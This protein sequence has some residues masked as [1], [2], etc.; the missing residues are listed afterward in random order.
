M[1]DDRS[2]ERAARSWIED[3]PTRAPDSAVERALLTIE[4]TPQERDLRILRRFQTMP[5]PLRVA[6][7][8]GIGVL[9]IGGVLYALGGPSPN[10]GSLQPTPGP[11]SSPTQSPSPSVS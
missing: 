4:T 10:V 7:A 8:A 11:S 1:T 2:L 3:G 6:A 5:A 9:L